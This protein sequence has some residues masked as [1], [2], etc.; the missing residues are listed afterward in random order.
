[1]EIYGAKHK[2]DVPYSHKTLTLFRS[3]L[4]VT[5]Y[6]VCASLFYVKRFKDMHQENCLHGEWSII[7][8]DTDDRTKFIW[9]PHFF[10]FN[11]SIIFKWYTF[12]F[13]NLM[14]DI[15]KPNMFYS[16]Y[17]KWLTGISLFKSS[18]LTLNK[19]YSWWHFQKIKMPHI[20]IYSH[21]WEYGIQILNTQTWF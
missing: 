17:C 19:R 8:S 14:A 7:R 10:A 15:D 1:M 12:V 21:A 2:K 18:T 3:I 5:Y 20:N 6:L 9:L 16:T 4:I 13:Y 11:I